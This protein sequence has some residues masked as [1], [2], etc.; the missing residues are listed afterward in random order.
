[1]DSPPLTFYEFFAGGGMARLGLGVD[2]RCLFANDL[3]PLKAAAYRANFGA[4][5]LHVGDVWR[6]Q[7]GGLPGHADLAWA[8]SP[9]QDLSLAGRRAGLGGA[10]SS[11]FWGFWTLMTALDAEGRA[12]GV[13]VIEN[14]AGLLTSHHGHDFTELCRALAGLRYR[15]G[16]LEIDAA[17]FVP[18]SRPRL[19]VVATR[20]PVPPEGL[21]A[22]PAA[23]FHTSR[24]V[25]A[26]Q[27]LPVALREAWAWWALPCPPPPDADLASLLE[28]DTAVPWRTAEQT[29]RLLAQLGPLHRQRLAAAAQAGGRRVGALF[30]RTRREGAMSVQ[31]A[32]L[33]FDGLAGC[34][35]TPAGGSSRQFVVVVQGGAV[36]TRQL[37]PREAARLMGLPDGYR[38]PAAATAA[39]QVVGD[40]VAAPV[41]RHLA[42]G[43]L[44]PLLAGSSAVARAPVAFAA[45]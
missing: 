43:L 29:E 1:M 40:G 18:Q 39:L 35:R 44:Q 4:D 41:V 24:L 38:L 14:V 27:R 25:A 34:L 16:A 20:R 5:H 32:E 36:R 9:C 33:R 11:A 28:P 23:P 30:R 37:T 19:F 42:H 22:K 8:S 17:R 6:L 7:A 12:P 21:L 31:R 2:W 26:F 10:R 3:D 15:F 13:I 45:E